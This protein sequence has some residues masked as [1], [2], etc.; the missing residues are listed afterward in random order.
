VSKEVER[1]DWR[2]RCEGSWKRVRDAVYEA[3]NAVL[4]PPPSDVVEKIQDIMGLARSDLKQKEDRGKCRDAAN[5][6]Q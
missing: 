4:G 2:H 3:V 6:K 1:D 5:D